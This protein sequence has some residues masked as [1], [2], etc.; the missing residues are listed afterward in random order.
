MKKK[1]SIL[2]A[3]ALTLSV[4]LVHAEGPDATSS[5]ST[6]TETST[7]SPAPAPAKTSTPASQ[8]P[9]ASVIANNGIHVV[10]SGD[11]M[12]AIAKKYGLSLNQLVVLNPQ[13]TNAAM[14]F[15]GDKV[16]LKAGVVETLPPA[17]INPT[18][19]YQGLGHTVAFRNG[20]GKDDEGVPV[21]SFNIVMASAAF[22][23]D[24]RIINVYLDGY[25]VATPNYDGASM[26]HFSGWPGKEGYN[27]FNHETEKISGIK[28]NT[29]E[30]A[31][32]E[33]NS[34]KTKRERGDS[35]HM[36]PNNEW[37]K[38]MDFFQKFFV[39]KTVAELKDWYAKNTTAAGRPIKLN[40]TNAQE[41]EKLAKLT[42]AEKAVLADVVS[43]A[44]MSM[45]DGHGD[46]LGAIENAYNNRVEIA[47]KAK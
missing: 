15:P 37:Y 42:E 24:G 38:Q 3:L 20:P 32:A 21:Y 14:I 28:S 8:A 47:L 9:A 22:D 31:V 30:T 33:V 45:S 43:G 46:F 35:Y 23:A 12:K 4:S 36:N 2:L 11:T 1:V 41:K 40:T 19:V 44:T 17:A 39:G 7:S 34:W 5:A 27:E 26:P 10:A 18:K 25:E 16:F 29:P 6:K 13:I